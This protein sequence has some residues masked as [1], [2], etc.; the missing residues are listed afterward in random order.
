MT[1]AKG[2]HPLSQLS[3]LVQVKISRRAS[4]LLRER[5][6]RNLRTQASYLRALIYRDLNLAETPE[7]SGP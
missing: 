3:V 4:R 2:K 1:A 5:A 7:S 6:Q